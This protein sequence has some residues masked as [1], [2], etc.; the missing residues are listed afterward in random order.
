MAKDGVDG[1]Y[2]SDPKK[3]KNAE[4]FTHLTFKEAISRKLKVMD[5]AAM[6][7]CQK[8][9]NS[10]LVFNMERKNA[11]INAVNRTIPVTIVDNK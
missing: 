5:L 8:K 1:V 3:N 2:S 6:Q 9:K 4:R 10:I 7:I 11:I